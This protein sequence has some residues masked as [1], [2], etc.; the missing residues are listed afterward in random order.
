[1]R[2]K[3]LKTKKKKQN[4]KNK[5][6]KQKTKPIVLKNKMIAPWFFIFFCFNL[7]FIKK[8]KIKNKN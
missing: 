2:K 3:K 7:F 1:L 5:N 8:I 6:K 4:K